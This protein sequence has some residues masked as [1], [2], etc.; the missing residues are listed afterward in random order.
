MKNKIVFLLFLLLFSIN[1]FS[2]EFYQGYRVVTWEEIE[3]LDFTVIRSDDGENLV[4]VTNSG[5]IVDRI[6]RKIIIKYRERISSLC[7]LR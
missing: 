7:I 2:Q 3:G 6:K 5:E 4:K 1:L